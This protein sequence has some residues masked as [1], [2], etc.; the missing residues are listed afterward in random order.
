MDGERRIGVSEDWADAEELADF[1]KAAANPA[2]LRILMLLCEG[3]MQVGDLEGRLKLGQAYVSQQL[4]RLRSAG[5][6]VGNRHGR[7]VFYSL[8]DSR[9][10][11][12]VE[13]LGR[14]QSDQKTRRTGG[15]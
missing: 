6:V 8:L 10:Q 2:R 9:V 1:L 4:A 14:L 11:P 13:L 5:L 7:E 3:D 12:V 15:V